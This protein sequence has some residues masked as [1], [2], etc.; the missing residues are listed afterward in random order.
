M[1]SN[2]TSPIERDRA[3]P[4]SEPAQ[5]PVRPPEETARLLAFTLV[6]TGVVTL[7]LAIVLSV[8]VG[9]V[10]LA[11]AVLAVI[12]FVLAAMFS[13]GRIGP[14]AERRR[15]AASGDAAAIA[16]ADPGFNPYARE[17]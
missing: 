7:A 2:P 13:S 1:G 14:L 4:I 9:P 8:I 15:A 5:T 16:E 17:D 3:T 11:I 12:D 6:F 10:W